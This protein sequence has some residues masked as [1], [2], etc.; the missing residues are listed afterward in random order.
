[1]SGIV[2]FLPA[3]PATHA[4]LPA[5]V[6]RE[7][8]KEFRTWRDLLRAC[9][10]PVSLSLQGIDLLFVKMTE[11]DFTGINLVGAPFSHILPSLYENA[12]PRFERH[13]KWQ[14][15]TAAVNPQASVF[16]TPEFDIPRTDWVLPRVIGPKQILFAIP[17]GHT[18]MY[19]ECDAEP[20]RYKGEG[21]LKEF[22]AIE[23][24][25]KVVVP[26]HGVEDAQKAFFLWQRYP[27]NELLQDAMLEEFRK[28]TE[29][30]QDLIRVFFMDLEAPL[31][32]SRYGLNIWDRFLTL[33]LKHFRK[34]IVPLEVAADV[35]RSR[36][37]KTGGNTYRYF[38]RNLG[39]KW[40]GFHVQLDYYRDTCI[41]ASRTDVHRTEGELAIITSSDVLCAMDRELCE[42]IVLPSDSGPVT[43]GFDRAVIDAGK[44]CLGIRVGRPVLSEVARRVTGHGQLDA[45][46]YLRFIDWIIKSQD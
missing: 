8:A 16:F 24:H 39:T 23:F 26:M 43:I 21:N 17:A 40:T 36:A 7:Y 30:G 20:G 42:P 35:W 44:A 31:I 12:G 15:Q 1:M 25:D 22:E 29:D 11:A 45:G 41:F 2:V 38:A 18:L 37:V 9:G 5:S 28:I 6:R 19:S 3:N 46:S 13:L 34:Y 10:L 32:G 14:F 27:N 33:M 4:N